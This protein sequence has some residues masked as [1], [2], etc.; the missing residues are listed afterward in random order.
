MW[1]SLCESLGPREGEQE[2]GRGGQE[3]VQTVTGEARMRQ[4]GSPGLQST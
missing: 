4:E 3:L 2:V 1:G